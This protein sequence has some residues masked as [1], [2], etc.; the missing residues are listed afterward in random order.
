MIAAQY[1]ACICN[2]AACISGSGELGAIAGIFYLPSN[3][4]LNY[5]IK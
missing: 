5:K 1:L 4:D 2:I 3:P